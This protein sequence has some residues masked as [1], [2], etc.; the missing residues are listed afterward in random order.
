[1]RSQ[2]KNT[3]KNE[4][5]KL[6]EEHVSPVPRVVLDDVVSFSFDP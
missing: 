3:I 6:V 1:M 2:F 5:R 4:M